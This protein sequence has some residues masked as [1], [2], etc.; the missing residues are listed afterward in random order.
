MTGDVRVV[1]DRIEGQ[2]AV[3]L[4]GKDEVRVDVPVSVL[5]PGAGEGALL[6]AS[7]AL[8]RQATEQAIA[9]ARAR[10]ERLRSLSRK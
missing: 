5:P 4:V 6:R 8:D 3:L 9:S 7:F 1:V 10:I 2:V